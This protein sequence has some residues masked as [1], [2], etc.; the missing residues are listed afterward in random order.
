[1][2]PIASLSYIIFPSL[3]KLKRK[4]NPFLWSII[5]L[6][7]VGCS[8]KGAQQFQMPP[9]EVDVISA[10]PQDFPLTKDYVGRLSP[11]RSADARA[12]VAGV[13]LQKSYKEGD[14]VQK[15]DLLFQ[16]DSEPFEAAL[17]ANTAALAQAE[18]TYTN[19]K[20]AAERARKLV[21][22][23]FVT[24]A[25]LDN[26]EANERTAAA[27]VEEAKANVHT[28]Q[29]S[30]GYTK[31]V[32]PI[33]GRADRQQ[34]T[35]GALVGQLDATLLTTVDQIDPLY[36]NFTVSITEMEQMR[37]AKS[38]EATISKLGDVTVQIT[39][40]SKN[41]YPELGIVDFSASRVNPSTGAVDLRATVPNVD[42]H[43]LP[44][45]YVTLKADL[46]TLHNTFLIPQEAVLRDGSGAYVMVVDQEKKVVR[47]NVIAERMHQGSWLITGGLN[48]NDQVIV[49]GLQKIQP[50]ISVNPVPWKVNNNQSTDNSSN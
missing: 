15:G 39:L 1:M 50:G 25:D 38:E 4:P 22:K 45:T 28:A 18:A 19:N 16:I 8:D 47:H 48:T 49:S 40:P 20:I 26:A 5:F 13:V 9:P 2:H 30:L 31:V 36:A 37:R 41:I 21:T 11:Y 44:G 6:I 24:E 27:A 43:L 35:E 7:L 32:A 46:G 14:I 23:G 42:Y 29:I 34:V 17:N 33:T 3:L 12:R 10:T